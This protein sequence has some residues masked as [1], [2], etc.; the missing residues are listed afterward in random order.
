MLSQYGC[1]VA[2]IAPVTEV[3]FMRFLAFA[4]LAL[5]FCANRSSAQIAQDPGGWTIAKWGMT[6]A[7]LKEAFPQAKVYNSSRSG[8]TFG[9][10]EYEMA[11]ARVHV[12]FKLDDEGGLQSVLIEP[13]EKSSAD[14]ALDSPAPTVARIGEILLLAGLKDQFGQPSEATVEPSFDETGQVTHQ[15]RW[16]FPGTSV[17]LIW[18]SYANPD[19]EG[20]AWTY[21]VYEKTLPK[22]RR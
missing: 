13:D 15:W 9:I 3:R 17:L 4:C 18:N 2:G 21:L 11:G 6:A 1:T 7:G 5:A 22:T 8:P 10:P 19:Y 16:S 14:P 20:R 12:A